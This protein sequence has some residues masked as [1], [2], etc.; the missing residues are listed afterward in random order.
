[1]SIIRPLSALATTLLVTVLTCPAAASKFTTIH[2]FPEARFGGAGP[3]DVSYQNGYLIGSALTGGKFNIVHQRN[4][5]LFKLKIA[6]GSVAV[7]HDFGAFGADGTQPSYAPTALGGNLVGLTGY[8]GVNHSGTLYRLDVETRKETILHTFA[9]YHDPNDGTTPDSRLLVKDNVFYGATQ[10]GG[11]GHYGIL[12]S[13][14]PTTD[15]ETVLYNFQNKAD[16]A[17]P[18]GRL[19][20]DNGNLYGVTFSGGFNKAGTSVYG[21][22]YKLNI[23]TRIFTVLHTFEGRSG[24]GSLP[25]DMA[26]YGHTLYGVTENGGTD[27]VGAIFSFDLDTNIEKTVYSFVSQ[28]TGASPFFA[29]VLSNG[30]LYGTV[31]SG[32]VLKYGT[33]YSVDLKFGEAKVLYNFTGG[34][35]GRVPDN[36]IMHDGVFYGATEFAGAKACGSQGCGTL[37]SFVP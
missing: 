10:I 31:P 36:L 5:I 27:G 35:D 13:L 3:K 20:Y 29:P 2:V 6:T 33:I 30:I 26:L 16:G 19:I 4:G 15:V 25:T 14:D 12:F 8:G 34:S 24:S 7:L 37:F 32:G 17:L 28:T 1:M 22:V 23:A 18:V 11:T 21:T 9:N